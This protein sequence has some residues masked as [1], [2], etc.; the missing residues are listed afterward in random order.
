[1]ISQLESVRQ[2]TFY[3]DFCKACH[4]LSV[5]KMDEGI[6]ILNEQRVAPFMVSAGETY[7][8]IPGLKGM[9]VEFLKLTSDRRTR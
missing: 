4:N 3:F 5:G 9:P 1:M 2:M 6:N 7:P 8:E